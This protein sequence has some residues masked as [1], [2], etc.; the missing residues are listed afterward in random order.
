MTANVR[1]A[2]TI[3]STLENGHEHVHDVAKKRPWHRTHS[4]FCRRHCA[5]TTNV[6]G[7]GGLG[8]DGGGLGGDGGDGLGG[9]GGFRV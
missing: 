2:M 6:G 4:S 9:D 5:S 3:D 7:D 1:N 8:G